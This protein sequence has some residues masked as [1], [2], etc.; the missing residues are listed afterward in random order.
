MRLKTAVLSFVVILWAAF[1]MAGQVTI[2]D[3]FNDNSL[4]ST[5]WTVFTIED[6]FSAIEANQ[7][8]ELSGGFPS[9]DAV[10]GVALAIP[11]AAGNFDMQVDFELLVWPAGPAPE[12][13]LFAFSGALDLSVQPSYLVMLNGFDYEASFEV[14]GGPDIGTEIPTLDTTGRLRLTGSGPTIAAYYWSGSAWVLIQQFDFPARVDQPLWVGVFFASDNSPFA[15]IAFDN[16]TVTGEFAVEAMVTELIQNVIDLNLQSGISNSLDAKLE[17]V[18]HVLDELNESN[19]IAAINVLN[20][21][22]NAVEAQRGKKLS[23]SDADELIASALLI[24]AALGG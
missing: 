17:T 22:S 20:A 7:R 11:L 23:E 19:D 5:L 9:P 18:L 15:A 10:G 12:G 8:L 4:D 14:D 2:S 6:P 24:I 16:F 21:F 1:P 13:G 3:D